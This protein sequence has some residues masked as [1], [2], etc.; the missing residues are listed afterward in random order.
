MWNLVGFDEVELENISRDEFDSIWGVNMKFYRPSDVP[1]E[2]TYYRL[3]RLRLD[4]T[5]Q[6]AMNV[7]AERSGGAP[8]PGLAIIQGWR[9]GPYLPDDAAPTGWQPGNYPNRGN[10]CFTN[11]N[12]VADWIWG[13]GEGFAPEQAEGPHWYWVMP[14]D[15]GF[16]SDVV[17]GFGWRWGTPHHHIEAVFVKG[18]GGDVPPPVGETYSV[19]LIVCPSS[20]MGYTIKGT[21]SRL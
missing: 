10:G 13:S 17:C 6:M 3:S 19:D 18:T 9:D 14:G 2:A 5:G 16:Y 20:V 15:N 7:F 11:P 4:T 1:Q 21:I 12:G 8:D